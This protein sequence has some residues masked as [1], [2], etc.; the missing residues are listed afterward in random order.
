[1]NE[2]ENLNPNSADTA[3]TTETIHS[4]LLATMVLVYKPCK[5]AYSQPLEETQNAE[6]GAYVF[7][8]NGHSLRFRVAKITPTKVGQFVTL[9]ERVEK[10]PIQ[11]YDLS[12]SVDFFVISTREGNNWGQFVFPKAVLYEQGVLSSGGKGGKRAIRVYPPWDQTTSKQA[13][14]TQTWQ[15]KYFLEIPHEKPV[16]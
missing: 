7:S 14:K 11:P 4:D 16:D 8:L 2:I 3:E 10:G 13:Q 9:W 15:L 5:L 1:M 12:N 6:Y